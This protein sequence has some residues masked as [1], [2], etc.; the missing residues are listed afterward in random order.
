[1]DLLAMARRWSWTMKNIRKCFEEHIVTAL[2]VRVAE[3]RQAAVASFSTRRSS[4]TDEVDAYSVSR[5]V[6]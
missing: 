4:S 1:M 6:E 5:M 3:G 2:G